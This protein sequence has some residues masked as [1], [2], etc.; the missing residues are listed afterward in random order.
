MAE[1]GRRSRGKRR[2][3]G[4]QGQSQERG[5]TSGDSEKVTAQTGSLS[6]EDDPTT[7]ASSSSSL[8]AES[9]F[10][11]T[12]PG[13]PFVPEPELPSGATASSI[14]T[15][16]V[17]TPAVI[18][19]LPSTST[20]GIKPSNFFPPPRPKEGGYGS[21]G[22][23]IP[24][25]L[26]FFPIVIPNVKLHM[27]HIDVFN[28]TLKSEDKSV[29]QKY[30][31]Q[32]VMTALLKKFQ[33]DF[34]GEKPVYDRQATLYTKKPL[35][36]DTSTRVFKVDWLD[37]ENGDRKRLHRVVFT[38]VATIDLSSIQEFISRTKPYKTAVDRQED[39]DR[40]RTAIQAI[41]V[42]MR[43]LPQS[44][45]VTVGRSFYFDPGQNPPNLGEGCDIWEGYFQSLRPGQW[46]PFI[47]IDTSVSGMMKDLNLID[48]I[49]DAVGAQDPRDAMRKKMVLQRMLCNLK[50]ATRHGGFRRVYKI[51]NSARKVFGQPPSQLKFKLEEGPETNAEKYF[52]QKYKIRLEYP[53]LPCIT[54]GSKGTALPMEVCTIVK[55][56][57]KLGKLTGD[58]T[59][60]MIRYAAKPAFEKEK[61]IQQIANREIVL[62]DPLLAHYGIKPSNK[63]IEVNGRIL[64]I[65]TII[66]SNKTINPRDGSWNLIDVVFSVG[67]T[68]DNW[69][70]LDFVGIRDVG[71]F[72]R[73]VQSVGG[74]SGMRINEPRFVEN[75]RINS[76]DDDYKKKEQ[77]RQ[78]FK[79]VHKNYPGLQMIVV[80]INGKPFP[81]ENK[82]MYGHIKTI[83]DSELGVN[84]QCVKDK[85]LF[86]I[87]KSTIAN[88]CLKMN[89]KLGG[90]NHVVEMS[91]SPSAELFKRPIMFI[92]ADVNHPGPGTDEY[93]PSI[94]AMVGS[95]DSKLAKYV[96]CVRFQKHS[97]SIADKIKSDQP[98]KRKERLEMIDK[99]EDMAY[100]V[101]QGFRQFCKGH[102]P[103]RIIYYRDGVSEGQF[104]QVL[105]WE[106]KALR[107]A[108]QRFHDEKPG[109]EPAI[110]LVCVQKRHHLRMFCS[111]RRDQVGKGGNVPPGTCVDKEVTH[112]LEFDFFLCSHFGLQGTS[113]PTHYHV[114]WDENNFDAN[115]LQALTYQLCHTYA[116]CTKAVS[117]PA[118]V[119]YAHWV[120]KRAAMSANFRDDDTSSVSSGSSGDLEKWDLMRKPMLIEK[121]L[122]YW[123]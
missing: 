106:L 103:E 50:I 66:Y 28:D 30:V 65:P 70:I 118:P 7:P 4:G 122:M 72:I 114:L 76:R 111:D 115:S 11:P 123:A 36:G 59:A 77:I 117:I 71:Q 17:L 80:F 100:E 110:T 48:F 6:L 69:G 51:N 112:N 23:E 21:R 85:N 19:P 9:P 108:A 44:K 47:N 68:M 56:Q 46:K 2:G 55:G 61:V 12:P 42:I 63:M 107:R 27:Y 58:Q 95:I 3:R 49:C 97:R 84:S 57:H 26:N 40:G 102:L 67:K 96:S 29:T 119:Y 45:H 83:C 105:D 75:P 64:D 93:T 78:E 62:N 87:N 8:T 101:L 92:G 116:R 121:G 89:A 113:R 94:A 20:Q 39:F 120:A 31:C 99:F 41:E 54:V 60:N 18:P 82:D 109:Y 74:N 79:R 43:Q 25:R 52:M 33:S 22:R 15:P 5:S 16:P 91:R 1:R 90:I 73:E 10:D 13:V 14:A 88:I 37:S 24:L 32:S 98:L 104:I 81:I 38:K 86:K 34:P 35:W 53:D